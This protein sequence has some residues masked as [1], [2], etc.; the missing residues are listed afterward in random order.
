MP[1]CIAIA[2]HLIMHK[3]HKEESYNATDSFWREELDMLQQYSKYQ[4]DRSTKVQWVPASAVLCGMTVPYYHDVGI[5]TLPHTHTAALCY[6]YHYYHSQ[7]YD[8]CY[9]TSSRKQLS[10]L[11]L[12]CHH[13]AMLFLLLV[14]HIHSSP[15][16]QQYHSYHDCY[17]YHH[18]HSLVL[19][20][21][22]A[23][24]TQEA[25]LA[26]LTTTVLQHY[27]EL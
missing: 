13:C 6:S 11:P 19:F 18:N 3:K 15:F 12:S 10:L 21:A 20:A 22:L 14:P 23:A 16:S 26:T 9:H 1:P 7:Y 4:W 27:Q 2:S 8:H 24:T 5:T 25:V 17:Q